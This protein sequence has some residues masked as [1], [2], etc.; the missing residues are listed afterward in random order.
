MFALALLIAVQT[1]QTDPQAFERAWAEAKDDDKASISKRMA[2]HLWEWSQAQFSLGF[3]SEFIP[4]DDAEEMRR[5]PDEEAMM[6]TELGRM[7]L[8]SANDSFRYG[9]AF[10]REVKPTVRLCQKELDARAAALRALS[11]GR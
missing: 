10:R 8:T 4:A 3:C 6:K 11:K 7:L 2:I 9:M 1:A 5:F